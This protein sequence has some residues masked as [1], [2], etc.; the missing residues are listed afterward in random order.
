MTDSHEATVAFD[1]KAGAKKMV[2]LTDDTFDSWRTSLINHLVLKNLED[3]VLGGDPPAGVTDTIAQRKRI[4]TTMIRMSLD[5]DNESR[6]VDRNKLRVLNLSFCLTTLSGIMSESPPKMQP[7][8][9][10]E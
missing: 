8:F 3:L 5:K 7:P 4:A 6:F 2:V 9:G 10:I 1:E